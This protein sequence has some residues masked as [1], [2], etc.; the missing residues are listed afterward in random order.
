MTDSCNGTLF[1]LIH[2]LRIYSTRGRFLR[3]STWFISRVLCQ[4]WYVDVQD[5]LTALATH[6]LLVGT[7]GQD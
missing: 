5:R 4:R 6:G 2:C 1:F 7:A 3:V